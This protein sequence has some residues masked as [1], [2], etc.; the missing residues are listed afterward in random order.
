MVMDIIAAPIILL[1][2]C[3]LAR[4]PW[5]TWLPTTPTP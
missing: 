1:V 2:A 4:L 5:A 3:T